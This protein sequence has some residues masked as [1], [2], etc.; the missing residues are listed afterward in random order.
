MSHFM[1]LKRRVSKSVLL[2]VSMTSILSTCAGCATPE[3]PRELLELDVMWQDPETNKV[4]DIPGAGAYYHEAYQFRLRA[5]E[6]YNDAELD[7][8]REY[9]IWS[10]LKYRTA[11]AI[12]RQHEAA[13]R[14]KSA[15]KRVA[16]INPELTQINA[17]RNAFVQKVAKLKVNIT[18]AKRI[19]TD[20][21][22]RH[23]AIHTDVV[24]NSSQKNETVRVRAVDDKIATVLTARTQA[25]SV[26]AQKH[27]AALF[28]RAENILKSIRILRQN[29]PV[30][31]AQIMNSSDEAIKT[32]IA[33]AQKAK[34]GY[35]IHVAKQ[36]PAARR[37]SLYTDVKLALGSSVALQDT[38]TVRVLAPGAYN[39]KSHLILSTGQRAIDAVAKLA[40]TYDEFSIFIEVYTSRG[41]VT[42][43]LALSQLRAVRVRD[44]LVA[45]GV[46]KK[47]L[48]YKGMGQDNPRYP[49]EKSRNERI[50]F[51]FRR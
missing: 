43:N 9:A 10:V 40:K 48:K 25:T 42:E 45:A 18:R 46:H 32:Y 35:S 38:S 47:R 29:S 21:A 6:A 17:Q 33:S 11:V 23:K 2:I 12:A 28:N 51:V 39:V 24:D 49:D 5:R 37:A 50:E 14:L 27:A 34:P 22:S 3:K 15:N 4:K 7:L 36:D 30:P 19:K 44:A 8:A 13:G 16:K 26:G 1:T 20:A 31:Y 41:D